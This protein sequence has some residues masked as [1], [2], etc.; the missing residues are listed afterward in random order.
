MNNW[1]IEN[2]KTAYIIILFTLKP[3][4]HVIGLKNRGDK[5]KMHYSKCSKIS[6]TFL[7]ILK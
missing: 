7:S 3:L 2:G 4:A 5:K 6:S 1:T